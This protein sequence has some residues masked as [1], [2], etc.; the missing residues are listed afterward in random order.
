MRAMWIGAAA[1]LVMFAA[2][3]A[4]AAT[5]HFSTTLKGGDEV[6]PTDSK[7]TGKVSA[8]L[9]TASKRFSYTVTY[10]GLT[11]PA[12]MAHFH[13]PALAGANAG[14]Q[15]PVPKSALASPMKGAAVLTDS[16]VSDLEAG[17]WYFNIHTAANP[18][19]EVRGQLEEVK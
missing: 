1:A 14:V 2:G 13:G 19:G 5:L 16:Q 9:D 18:P 12:T 17:K 10:S 11:G 8:T 6:P 15:V 3:A 7:G 4:S